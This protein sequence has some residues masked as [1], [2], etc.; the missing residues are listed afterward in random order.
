MQPRANAEKCCAAALE[1]FPERRLA[2]MI[3]HLKTAREPLPGKD[4]ENT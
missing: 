1:T 3:G 2:L 4:E